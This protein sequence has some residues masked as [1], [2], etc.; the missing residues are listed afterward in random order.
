MIWNSQRSN[1]RWRW[2]SLGHLFQGIR[3]AML[4]KLLLSCHYCYGSFNWT[5]IVPWLLPISKLNL[6]YNFLLFYLCCLKSA[7]IAEIR[8]GIQSSSISFPVSSLLSNASHTVSQSLRSQTLLGWQGSCK[9]PDWEEHG[10]CSMWEQGRCL[11]LHMM[12]GCIAWLTM[13]SCSTEA[14]A[15][16]HQD[17]RYLMITAAGGR[18]G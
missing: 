4:T 18:Y 14:E 3:A 15:L 13:R 11:N 8:D 16:R 17:L 10:V 5:L 6:F 1:E 2:L 12:Q 9:T 7:F